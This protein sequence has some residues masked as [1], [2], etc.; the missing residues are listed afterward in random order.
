MRT[1]YTLMFSSFQ[2]TGSSLLLVPV[3][4]LHNRP[5]YFV[6]DTFPNTQGIPENMGR[7]ELVRTVLSLRHI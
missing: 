5:A 2:R 4:L 6:G 1:R 3:I 7:T